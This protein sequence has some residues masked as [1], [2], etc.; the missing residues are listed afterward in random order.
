MPS[1]I[2]KFRVKT[3]EFGR[4]IKSPLDGFPV[5]ALFKHS[6]TPFAFEFHHRLE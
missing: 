5:N 3:P 1:K 6:P 2:S 4:T